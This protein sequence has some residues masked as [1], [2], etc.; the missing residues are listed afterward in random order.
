VDREWV[1]ATIA[2]HYAISNAMTIAAGFEESSATLK[3][4]AME[5]GLYREGSSFAFKSVYEDASRTV[6]AEYRRARAM[7][8]LG[9]RRGRLH[10]TDFFRILRDHQ[11]GPQS[12][13][14]ANPPRICA[15]A[16]E[17]PL[18]QTTGSWVASLK[19]GKCIHWV[20]GTSAPCTGLFKPVL[21]EAGL[22]HHGTLPGAEPDST[23]LWWRHEQLRRYL[24][25]S[26]ATRNA[27]TEERDALEASF[28]RRIAVSDCE[29]RHEAR[30]MVEACWVDA[31]EF[32]NGWFERSSLHH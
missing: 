26:A 11:E 29:D 6:G 27:F 1:V 3:V 30:R 12:S 22:P 9:E 32:E 5:A 24:D 25:D 15:H 7:T 14:H 17:N 4:R 13:A 8:L 10:S 19:P 16:R 28:L 21:F 20:T 18:G 23:S 2:D 31:L